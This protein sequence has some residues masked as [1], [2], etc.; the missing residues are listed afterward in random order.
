VKK[1]NRTI[2]QLEIKPLL[3]SSTVFFIDEVT[4]RYVK[5]LWG[6]TDYRNTFTLSGKD[7]DDCTPGEQSQI[8]ALKNEIQDDFERGTTMA[9]DLIAQLAI[10]T[11]AVVN[12]RQESEKQTTAMLSSASCCAMNSGNGGA[13][14][15]GQPGDIPTEKP[16]DTL[17]CKVIKYA[18]WVSQDWFDHWLAPLAQLNVTE[19]LGALLASLAL[20]PYGTEIP[21]V[22]VAIIAGA[23][24]ISVAGFLTIISDKLPELYNALYCH[25]DS[26]YPLTQSSVLNWI[27]GVIDDIC[28][29]L[30]GEAVAVIKWL[31]RA[32]GAIGIISDGI[33]SKISIPDIGD[34]SICVCGNGVLDGWQFATHYPTYQDFL[35]GTNPTLSPPDEVTENY[36]QFGARGVSELVT[37]ASE[38]AHHY[39]RIV[40]S[41]EQC[42]E[43]YIGTPLLESFYLTCSSG[44]PATILYGNNSSV[45]YAVESGSFLGPYGPATRPLI[46]FYK[47]APTTWDG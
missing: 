8:I 31:F 3:G 47:V 6:V 41:D 27:D 33:T 9:Q 7:F 20:P 4:A 26:N 45:L 30:S 2:P 28:S 32:S 43:I 1:K 19:I 17:L 46:R 15:P 10:L 12:L 37:G 40:R 21:E 39:A 14:Q 11:Q 34:D 18:C 38:N 25:L 29:E 36:I 44:N 13:N 16:E 22:A 42:K 35:D 24:G 23:V 5:K